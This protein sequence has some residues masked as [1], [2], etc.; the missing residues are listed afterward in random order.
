MFNP[1]GCA[2]KFFG[3]NYLNLDRKIRSSVERLDVA[4]FF[5]VQQPATPPPPPIVTAVSNAKKIAR[6]PVARVI[7]TEPPSL[8]YRDRCGCNAGAFRL[9]QDICLRVKCVFC[10]PLF[11][12]TLQLLLYHRRTENRDTPHRVPGS[13]VIRPLTCINRSREGNMPRC[14]DSGDDKEDVRSRS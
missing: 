12:V 1:F 9:A 11:H 5:V 8:F 7:P 4:Y 14:E 13:E 2:P 6:I 3:P 10:R